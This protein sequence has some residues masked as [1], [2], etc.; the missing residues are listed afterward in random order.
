MSTGAFDRI[1][2]EQGEDADYLA[3]V[4]AERRAA[5]APTRFCIDCRHIDMT[6]AG[7]NPVW[8]VCAIALYTD[9]VSGRQLHRDCLTERNRDAPS[10]G[11]AGAHFEPR[12]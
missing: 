9:P 6:H 7:D 5:T 11:P 3:D 12:L 4:R 1:T 8:A 10:C 2:R